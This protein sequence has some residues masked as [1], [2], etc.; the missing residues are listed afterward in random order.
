MASHAIAHPAPAPL[1]GPLVTPATVVLALL[2]LGAAG[3]GAVRLV[4]GLGAVAN[5]NDGYPWGIW[6]AF[7]LA[8]G[9][10][11]ACG[12]FA[13]S[14][15]VY[16]LNKGEYHPLVRPAILASLLGYTLASVSLFFDIGRYWNAWRIFWPADANTSSTIFELATC[17]TAYILVMFVEFSPALAERF[18]LRRLGARLG[19]VL[20]LVS[21]LG[22]VLPTMHQSSIGAML[23]VFGDQIDPL[24]RTMMLPLL[25]LISCITMGF[26]MVIFEGTLVSIAFRRPGETPM[27]MRLSKYMVGLLVVYLVV[28]FADLAWRGAW[29]HAFEPGLKGAMFWIENALFALPILLLATAESRGRPSRL[30]L[31]AVCMAL[32]G[33]VL[34]IDCFLIGYDTGA[35]WHYFPSLWEVVFTAG[36]I[37]AEILVYIVAIRLLPV[38]PALE[39]P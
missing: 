39:K 2:A 27:L 33:C 24:W 38:L 30:F 32:A 8:T 5:I 26:A 36:A 4:Y 11:L 22:I 3:V 34:R 21:A 17:M 23:I 15:L 35:G 20:F 14:I 6:I 13:M 31:G 28:R 7:D 9:A 25:F 12:G 37:S 10:A 1:G 18:G 29:G 16:I 19:K